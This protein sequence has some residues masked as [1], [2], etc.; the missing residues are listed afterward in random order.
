[1]TGKVDATASQAGLMTADYAGKLDG[2]DVGAKT[3]NVPASTGNTRVPVGD[4]SGGWTNSDALV[5]GTVND[6]VVDMESLTV[7]EINWTIYTLQSVPGGLKVLSSAG[8]ASSV[9]GCLTAPT[10]IQYKDH[11]GTN[12]TMNLTNGIVTSIT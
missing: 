2:I 9:V 8:S 7:G 1:V 4:G 3:R 10:T 12:K 5:S 11:S 6:L